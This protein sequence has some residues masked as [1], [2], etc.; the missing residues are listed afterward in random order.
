M[1]LE[2]KFEIADALA[3][4]YKRTMTAQDVAEKRD[5]LFGVIINTPNSKGETLV[6]KVGDE[7]ATHITNLVL[8]RLEQNIVGEF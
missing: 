3:F 4:Q 6:S 5:S 7:D 2:R 8:Q 1:K